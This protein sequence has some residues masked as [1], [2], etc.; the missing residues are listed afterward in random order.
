[1]TVTSQGRL[2][3]AL[4]D[5]LNPDG[6]LGGQPASLASRTYDQLRREIVAGH[7]SPGARLGVEALSR[8][9]GVGASA[10]REALS[11]LSTERFA[12]YE[13][14]KG[15]RAAPVSRDDLLEL[16]WTRSHLNG[17][18][19]RESISRGDATW[20]ETIV[21]A[22]HRL[23]KTSAQPNPAGDPHSDYERLHRAFHLSLIGAC[24]S[25]WLLYFCEVL[26]DY[27]ERYRNLVPAELRR[28]R[29]EA[30]EHREIMDAVIS[31][32]A[33]RAVLLLEKHI[34]RTAADVLDSGEFGSAASVAART[35]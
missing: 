26:F 19:L 5:D 12:F 16:M 27:S 3:S 6:G 4:L 20:E 32:D 28:P 8:R 33:D 24:G 18:A 9:L 2:S 15:F 10:I 31:R 25:R 7:I 22:L 13:E 11:R 21:L 29:D 14:Q 1:M 34:E 17:I 30:A 35:A 23:N